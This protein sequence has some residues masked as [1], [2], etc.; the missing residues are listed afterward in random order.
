ML[1]WGG[2]T[3]AIGMV[4]VILDLLMAARKKGGIE[5]ADKKRIF[6]VF[7]L[8]LAMTAI[9]VALVWLTENA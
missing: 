4:F 9:V 5:L 8:T 2:V 1:K 7:T 6:S 3:F